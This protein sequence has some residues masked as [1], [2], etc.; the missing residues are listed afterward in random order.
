MG[1]THFETHA[2]RTQAAQTSQK[3]HSVPLYLTSSFTFDNVEEGAA[4]FNG[5]VDGNLY[6]RF[7]NPNCDEFIDKLNLLED[8]ESGVATATGMAAV[9][10]T[11][12]SLLRAGDHIIAYV[13]NPSM[14]AHFPG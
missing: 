8:T 11:L 6:S 5:D 13:S 4:L 3:E 7:S 9:F 14:P 12:A 1:N 2:I 10:V